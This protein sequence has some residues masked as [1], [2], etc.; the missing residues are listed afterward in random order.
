MKDCQSRSRDTLFIIDCRGQ[1]KQQIEL[2]QKVINYISIDSLQKPQNHSSKSFPADGV[3]ESN[4]QPNHT[5]MMFPDNGMI[6]TNNLTY[7]LDFNLSCKESFPVDDVFHASGVWFTSRDKPLVTIILIYN[8]QPEK[9]NSFE[10]IVEYQK[11]DAKVDRFFLIPPITMG[12]LRFEVDII[13]FFYTYASFLDLSVIIMFSK[14][15][16]TSC[17]NYSATF[18]TGSSMTSYYHVADLFNISHD[19]SS[20]YCKKMPN[21]YLVSLESP[22]EINFINNLLSEYF[23]A[24]KYDKE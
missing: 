2:V 11:K 5:F 12:T 23:T 10:K 1:V 7:I 18:N 13:S 14:I 24:R 8:K 6:A 19:E 3:M 22:Q 21:S 9:F 15:C 17:T 4:E 20:Q 16:E